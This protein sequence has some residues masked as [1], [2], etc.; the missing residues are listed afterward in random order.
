MVS[1]IGIIVQLTILSFLV[2]CSDPVD[3]V[4]PVVSN[5]RPLTPKASQ[6]H[7]VALLIPSSAQDHEISGLAGVFEN[8]ARLGLDSVQPSPIELAVY[9]TQGTER[10]AYVAAQLA[11][12]EGAD[13]ILGPF[14]STSTRTVAPLANIQ[15]IPVFS[16]SNDSR[17]ASG[18]VFILGQSFE[19]SSE[20]ILN[21]A[22]NMGLNRAM[23]VHADTLSENRG[24]QALTDAAR[25]TGMEVIRVIS[26]E[27]TQPG[28]LQAVE[29]IAEAIRNDPP[30]IIILTGNPAG[31]VPLILEL[32][33]DRQV[34]EGITIAGIERW[35]IPRSTLT[36]KG[37][38]GS[39]FPNSDPNQSAIF[40]NLYEY[41]YGE[42]PHSLAG[43]PYNGIV[44]IN[45]LIQQDTDGVITRADILDGN[46]FSGASGPFRFNSDGTTE[47]SLAIVKIQDNRTMIIDQAPRTFDNLIAR[48][49]DQ[50]TGSSP[51]Q[52]LSR[53]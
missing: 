35:D 13:F 27:Y 24:A 53:N 43:L 21:Y 10:G 50:G 34:A 17:V 45:E 33:N 30:D 26:Y 36:V 47:Y 42:V 16:F 38:Q 48:D 23:I 25:N 20:R 22:Y 32:L 51:I 40:R 18:N 37:L 52:I 2:G 49:L 28:S 12:S 31:A 11:I 19:R 44:A 39:I 8:S 14:F 4:E 6:M 15:R 29:R 9:D 1:R 46:E 3:T 7:K 41:N 5:P